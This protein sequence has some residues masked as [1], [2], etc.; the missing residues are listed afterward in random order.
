LRDSDVFVGFLCLYVFTAS[1]SAPFGDAVPMWEAAQNLVRHGSFAID[2]RWPVNVP[3][4][5]G[6]HY[7][8]IAALLAC[9]VHVPGALLQTLLGTWA[10]DRMS[11]TA[12]LGPLVLGALVPTLF[13]RL[14]KQL[15]Y[16]RRQAAGATLL[17]GTGTSLWVYAHLPYSEIL[18]AA[19]FVFFLSALCSA[20]D[21]PARWSFLR[22]GLAA[23]LLVSSKNVY[24]VCLPGAGLFLFMRHRSQPRVLRTGLVWAGLGLL[25]GLVA[26]G[27]YNYVRWGSI[28]TSGYGGAVTAGFWRENVLVGLWGQFLSPGKS[29]FLYS[30]PLVLALFGIRRFVANRSGVALAIALTVGPVVLLYSRYIFWSGDWA[31]GPRYLVFALPALL[32]PVAELLG[33]DPS[34]PRPRSRRSRSAAIVAVGFAGVTV[35]VLGNAYGWSDFTNVSIEAQHAWLG[36]P[37]TG[38]TPL[39]PYPCFSCFEHLY[40]IQWLPPMQP[41]LGQW[42]LLRHHLAG[43]DWRTAEADAPWKRYTSLTLDIQK[44]Y[45]SAEIDWWMSGPKRYGL[46]PIALMAVLLVLP[47]RIRPWLAALGA[48]GDQNG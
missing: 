15:G 46:L 28:T 16:D 37:N 34:S 40:P 45:D 5:R 12:Q 9:L 1:R 32:L 25:P 35:Q 11:I 42:W 19:C 10:P 39:G 2:T 31:W 20:A 3:L 33:K 13:F 36:R 30:P 22:F 29:V 26:C 47:V 43:D 41:I 17:L 6:G 48:N 14:L 27:A 8:P 44:S 18:Q 4:G 38:G 23:T 21:A 24:F 7:Y